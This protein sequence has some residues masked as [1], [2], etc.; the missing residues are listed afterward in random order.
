MQVRG[1]NKIHLEVIFLCRA[2]FRR[3]IGLG[4]G[5]EKCTRNTDSCVID[6]VNR[7]NCK[8]C[9]FEKCIQVSLTI[10]KGTIIIFFDPEWYE[11]RKSGQKQD[12]QKENIKI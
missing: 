3:S 6:Q 4:K 5:F 1:W 8:K 12:L 10:A 9:R 11:A 2:F 7:A